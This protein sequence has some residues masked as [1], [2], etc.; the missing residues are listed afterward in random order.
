MATA[1]TREP[2]LAAE[3]LDRPD[4]VV[5]CSRAAADARGH[6]AAALPDRAELLEAGRHGRS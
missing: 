6:F 1:T 4:H 5:A 2:S 3:Q